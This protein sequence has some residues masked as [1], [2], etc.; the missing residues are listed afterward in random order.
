MKKGLLFV[1]ISTLLILTLVL[2]GC[3]RA[4]D[5]DSN[6]TAAS[7]GSDSSSVDS[8]YPLAKYAG[9]TVKLGIMGPSDELVWDPII[10]EFAK[11]GNQNRK[12]ILHR[13]LQD[14]YCSIPDKGKRR[15]LYRSRSS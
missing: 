5:S 10:E 15:S 14:P 1:L 2:A 11:K 6:S 12:S 4:D 7:S 13:L 9:T 8:D 3:G